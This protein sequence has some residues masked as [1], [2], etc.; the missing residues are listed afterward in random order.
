M[1]QKALEQD[2]DFGDIQ[3]LKDNLWGDKLV[4]D[5]EKLLANPTIQAVLAK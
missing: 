3:H 5:A 2:K 1:A 4:Q